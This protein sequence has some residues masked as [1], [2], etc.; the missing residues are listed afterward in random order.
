MIPVV[1]WKHLIYSPVHGALET[2]QPQEQT[3]CVRMT[4]FLV[5]EC[6]VR[7]RAFVSLDSTPAIL[8]AIADTFS[9]FSL[10]RRS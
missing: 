6:A 7:S 1:L 10:K 8:T 5:R 2:D 9:A 3:P 4:S